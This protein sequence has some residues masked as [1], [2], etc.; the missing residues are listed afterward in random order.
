MFKN[1]IVTFLTLASS[2]KSDACMQ[3]CFYKYIQDGDAATKDRCIDACYNSNGWVKCG[4][5]T[6]GCLE[7]GNERDG[8]YQ[9]CDDYYTYTED[10]YGWRDCE[11]MCS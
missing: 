1:F 10:E 2:A 8:C 5:L 3:E 4:D 11:N 6:F 7:C 9:R